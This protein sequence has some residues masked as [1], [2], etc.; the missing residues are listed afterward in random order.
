MGKVHIRLLLAI[1]LLPFFVAPASATTVLCW[2]TTSLMWN[3]VAGRSMP[4]TD[5]MLA[6]LTRAF[7]RWE[8]ASGGAL[9]LKYEGSDVPARDGTAGMPRDGCVHAVLYG[10]RNFHGELA[11]GGYE[12]KIPGHYER[13]WFFV[14]RKPNAWDE[15]TL[16]HEI[17]HTLGLPHSATPESVMFSGPRRNGAA[18][19]GQD[20]ADLRARWAH[21][22]PGVYVIEGQIE[23][24]RRHPVANVFAIGRDGR[25]FSARA[26]YMGRFLIGLSSPGEYRLVAR[27]VTV[28]RDLNPDALGGFRETEHPETVWVTPGHPNAVEVRLRTL[29]NERQQQRPAQVTTAGGP[30]ALPPPVRTGA[31]PVIRLSFDNGFDDEGPHR[32]KGEADGDDVRLVPGL[33]GRA[34]WVGGTADWLDVALTPEVTFPRG[35]TLEMWLRRDDW[36][37]PYKGGSGWQTV[38]A[39]TTGASLAITAPGCPLHKPWA[40]EA[41]VST[42]LASREHARAFSKGGTIPAKRWIHAAMVFDP[43]EKSLTVYL[44]GKPA[45]VAKG[46]PV[47]D[48]N[49][50]HLRLGTWFK[51]NQAFRG[52][53]DEVEVYDYPRTADDLAQAAR[54]AER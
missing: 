46:A 28:A 6:R 30:V 33:R 45:D 54:A 23:S 52:E 32:L 13:G 40:L 14:S 10:E 17:G 22:A 18:V 21:G 11:H 41:S 15:E 9:K 51:A 4:V 8:R 19:T 25:T 20:A 1:I 34:L 47:P 2:K 29:D 26:D 35:I 31:P 50:R 48:M 49:I 7:A 44:D 5:E 12:G 38:A 39:L 42:H 24:D 3:P 36:E 27:P 37:N 43:R 16:V 53:I